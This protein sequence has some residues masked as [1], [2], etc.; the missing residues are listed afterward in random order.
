[1]LVIIN[2]FLNIHILKVPPEDIRLYMWDLLTFFLTFL[3]LSS[4]ISLSPNTYDL[5]FIV[6]LN[7]YFYFS[8]IIRELLEED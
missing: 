3:F 7:D 2:Y 8:R 4:I 1:M 5:L 6:L